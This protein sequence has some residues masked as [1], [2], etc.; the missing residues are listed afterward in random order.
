[1]SELSRGVA[2][3]V[4]RYL[5]LI[6]FVDCITSIILWELRLCRHCH[7]LIS[8]QSAHL[9]DIGLAF[10]AQKELSGSL[11]GEVHQES[12]QGVSRLSP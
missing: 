8:A 1:M 10:L 11:D 4:D 12:R 9:L 7:L 6:V 5:L 3:V 2:S